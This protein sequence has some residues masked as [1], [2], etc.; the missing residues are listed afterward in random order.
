MMHAKST[1]LGL[2]P[3]CGLLLAVL[4]VAPYAWAE[5]YFR[6][7]PGPLNEGHAAYDNPDGCVK[8]H[9][10][11]KG[12]TN[13]KCLSCHGAVHHQGGLH[14][15]FGGKACISCHVEHKG[16]AFN[17][18]EWKGVGGRDT[19]KHDVTGF[20]LTNHHGQVACAKCHIKRLRT[21]RVSYLGVSKDCQSCHANAHGFTRPEL[22]QKCETC[23]QPGQSLVGQVLRNWHSQHAQFSKVKLD[24]KH[25]EQACVNCHKGGKMGGR[26]APRGCA[27][28]HVPSHPISNPTRDCAQCHAQNASFRGAKIK[29]EQ[30]GFPLVGKHARAGCGTCH[31]R[32]NKTGPG[33]PVSKACVDCHTA[34]HPVVKATANCIGCHAS[35]GSFKGAHIDHAKFSLGLFGKH[36]KNSCAS[37]HKSKVK[38]T[39]RDGDCTSC[40]THKKAHDGQYEPKACVNCHVEGGKRNKPFDHD[41]DTRFPLIGFH[42]QEKIKND[43]VLCHPGRLYRTGTLTCGDCHGDA[44]KGQL[45]KDCEKCHSPL[46]HFNAPRSK[47]FDH[48][49]YPLEGKHKTIPCVSCHVD[50]SYKISKHSCFD[51]HQKDDKH[52]G[53]L[54][55]T[56]D[57]CHGADTFQEAAKFSHDRM[58]RFARTGVHRQAACALCHQ[59]RSAQNPPLSV[60]AWKQTNVA[61]LTLDPT[62]P[63]RGNRCSE[64]HSDPHDGNLGSDCAACHITS[65][66]QRIS[67][68]RAK[69]IRPRDHGGSWLRRHTTLPE[70]DD[71]P[72]AEKR[73]CASCHG[74]P[75]CSN[76]HRTMAPRSHTALWRVRTHGAAA[77]FDPN[78][79]STCHR[80]A[81]C[82]QCH[83]RTPPLNH[84]GAWKQNHGFVAGGVSDNNCFVCHR[85]SD[86]TLCHRAR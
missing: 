15:T 34:T 57:Q 71:D 44:H 13:Q 43:C 86:C 30:F 19:F 72:G 75:T 64:C 67:G 29:H 6:V 8:C 77:S 79:C 65:D 50:K 76:C 54:G 68:G 58:T 38:L 59:A 4:L 48:K 24:G 21:G 28:C 62:F 83:R 17:I 22:S 81:T 84:R 39:Y 10:Q 40:H 18:I 61:T 63:V 74:T 80:A 3:L 11:N 45:G 56:C 73:S 7:S 33:R 36:L 51:C 12:V 52:Q 42:G 16:R 85:R 26:A 78:A 82:I 49:G 69:S 70:N 2:L 25:V 47:N 14:T 37:C 46:L 41:K 20:S 32:G 23:H 1:K 55:K 5:D 53:K 60:A 35:G 31:R 27:D 66:F 9:E